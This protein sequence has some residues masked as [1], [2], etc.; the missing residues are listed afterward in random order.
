MNPLGFT[1]KGWAMMSIQFDLKQIIYFC[2]DMAAMTAFYADVLG[3]RRVKNDVFP[4]DEWLELGGEGFKLCLHKAGAPGA[5]EKSRNKLVFRVKDVGAAR[6]HLI[7]RGIKM[8]KHHHWS[9]IDA[10]DGR[11]PEGNA[12]QI[13]GPSTKE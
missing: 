12:F 7:A 2:K 1:R 10:C 3:M 9:Q 11:D 8:G 4:E 6:E 5:P 13:A